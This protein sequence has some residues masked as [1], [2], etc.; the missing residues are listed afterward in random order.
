MN[1]PHDTFTKVLD[2]AD[3]STGGGSAS[4][5]AGGMA[6]A[7]IAMVCRLNVKNESVNDRQFLD[8]SGAIAL[9]L[10]YDL[11]GGAEDDG[12]AFQAVRDAYSLPKETEEQ[13]V[14]R[15]RSVQSAWV[16]AA[17]VPL[18]NSGK[19]VD[20]IALVCNLNGKTNPNAQSDLMSA[21]FLARAGCLGCLENVSINLP[22]IKDQETA[23]NI[24]DQAD[25]IRKRLMALIE[26]MKGV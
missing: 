3:T 1:I 22:S 23:A 2:P 11:L 19:C 9:Q 17:Q 24:N 14:A 12:M 7:L 18:I 8:D 6:G 20:L 25:E 13:R 15:L 5:L 21:V 4:A 16:N 10:S 26:L